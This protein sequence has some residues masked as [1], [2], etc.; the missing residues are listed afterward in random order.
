MAIAF[1][2]VAIHTRAK[3]HSAI[4]ASSYRTGTKLF[5][6]RTGQTHDF[7]NR[8]DVAY[9]TM[10]LPESCDPAFKNREY[11][12]NQ[13]E[14][15]EKRRDAQVCKDVVLALPK[16]LELAQHIEL[17]Q[18]FAQTHFVEQ[19]LPVDLAIHEHG[20]GNPHAH[21]L[22]PT[23]R[24]EKDGF[25][26]YKARDLNPA[27][28][29]G[30]VVEKDYWGELWREAQND[31]FIE[32][33]MDVS[34]D[35]NHFISE[36]HHGKMKGDKPHYLLGENQIIQQA[37]EAFA[38]DTVENIIDHLSQ[39]HSVFT[40]R[41]IERLLFKTFKDSQ[42][43]EFYLQRVEAVMSHKN[44]ILLGPNDQGKTCYT[45]REQYLQEARLRQA[46]EKMM[47]RKNHVLTN[48]IEKLS[49]RYGLSEEQHQ[50]FTYISQSPDISVVIGRPGTGKSYLLNPVKE[51]YEAHHY[52]VIGAALS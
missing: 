8:H 26:H 40:R 7:S 33:N 31:F 48:N 10:L 3:G 25:S 23:R 20:D 49:Q 13:A 43:T 4:A 36:R 24:L 28:A 21:L 6:S 29:K 22:I 47:L 17:A 12:W 44:I 45:T 42:K 35:L 34:V 1:A 15:A 14:L 38:L 41:D 5:D 32:K 27:F 46:I 18:R 51:H 2:H 16:E 52:Q 11:L 30:R 19:G 39:H 9:A 37:R 50:A